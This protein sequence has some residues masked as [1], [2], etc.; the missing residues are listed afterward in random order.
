MTRKRGR[1][2]RRGRYGRSPKRKTRGKGT[3]PLKQHTD[4]K[5]VPWMVCMRCRLAYPLFAPRS[6]EWR[7]KHDSHRPWYRNEGHVVR[8]FSNNRVH[9]EVGSG[10]WQIDMTDTELLAL[11]GGLED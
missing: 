5:L 2:A 10:R 3:G 1:V 11:L 8:V 6:K 9:R 7:A 4:P